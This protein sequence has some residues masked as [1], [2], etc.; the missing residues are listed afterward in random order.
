MKITNY[1]PSVSR[2][3]SSVVPVVEMGVAY[4]LGKSV[5]AD[6]QTIRENCKMEREAK[7][8]QRAYELHNAS[9][10]SPREEGE[11]T[12]SVDTQKD[13]VPAVRPNTK[14]VA[15]KGVASVVLGLD[16]ARRLFK[17]A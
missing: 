4:K 17:G 11:E 3:Q 10:P 13:F 8:H 15:V 6:V 2:V 16:G 7:A 12:L 9:S 14:W 1:I 5:F